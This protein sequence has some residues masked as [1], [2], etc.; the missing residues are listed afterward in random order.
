MYQPLRF[1]IRDLIFKS[2]SS[3]LTPRANTILRA[4]AHQLRGAKTIVCEGDTDSLGSYAS[5]YALGLHRAQAV[6][7]MLRRLGVRAHLSAMSYGDERPV[8][9]NR[10][11]AGRD[12][13]R[14]VVI[15]VSY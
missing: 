14:R 11:A 10:T 3:D 5:N 1:V 6:C 7:A 9:S 13:N 8:A 12:L 2:T 4:I 15:R